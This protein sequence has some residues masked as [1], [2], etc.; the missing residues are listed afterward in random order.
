MSSG[1]QQ[2]LQ[3]MTE[4]ILG[5]QARHRRRTRWAVAAGVAVTIAVAVPVAIV[6]SHPV[7]NGHPIAAHQQTPTPT[8]SPR[9]AG[10]QPS[11]LSDEAQIYA[12]VI[13][14]RPSADET[15][16]RI[17]VRDEFCTG[18]MDLSG[19][20]GAC[21]PGPIPMETQRQIRRIVGPSVHFTSAPPRPSLDGPVMTIGTAAIDG[22][23]AEVIVDM[24]C[25]PLCGQGATSVLTRRNGA[26]RVTGATGPG[27]I[28]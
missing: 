12:V 5:A 6:M 1:D 3:R 22:D 11:S 17:Y 19:S 20:R 16:R 25:G 14:G 26:W 7:T 10:G 9:T 8:S 21:R 27:W 28:S 13:G 23:R 15:R 24:Q 2:Q 4:D 18:L